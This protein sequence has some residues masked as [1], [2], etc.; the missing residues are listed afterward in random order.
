MLTGEQESV[1]ISSL[2]DKLKS[3]N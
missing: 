1:A 3:E 2:V